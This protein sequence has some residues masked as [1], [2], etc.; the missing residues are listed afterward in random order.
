M[1]SH[2]G[3]TKPREKP[4]PEPSVLISIHWQ[5]SQTWPKNFS[6]ISFQ[7]DVDW[8]WQYHAWSR[9]NNSMYFLKGQKTGGEWQVVRGDKPG[10]WIRDE[11]NK[12]VPADVGN[13]VPSTY[14]HCPFMCIYLFL[15]FRFF[16]F[17]YLFIY[18]LKGLPDFFLTFSLPRPRPWFLVQKGSPGREVNRCLMVTSV[19]C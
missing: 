13:P 2:I 9:L 11:E 8:Q 17:T 6:L 18:L 1:T 4:S 19:G 14:L 3:A 10:E 15:P 7:S 16:S 12:S 5:V